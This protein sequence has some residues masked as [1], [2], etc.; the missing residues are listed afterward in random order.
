VLRSYA[1][2]EQK[3]PVLMIN[4]VLFAI[5]II[6]VTFVTIKYTPYI[7]SLISNPEKFKNMLLSYGSKSILVYI[8]FQILHVIIVIIPGEVIQIAGGYVYGTFW[9]T[10]YSTIGI[11]IGM[12]IVFFA[13]RIFGFK[14]IKLL[15]PQ[16]SFDKFTFLINSEKSEIAMFVLFL[17]PGLPKDALSYIVG[18]TPIKPLRFL[19]IASIAR[20]PGLIGS[21]L[22]GA[23]LEKENYFLVIIISVI[24]CILFIAGV[25]GRD[26][27]INMIHNRIKRK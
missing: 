24:A 13:S 12:C 11:V 22:I 3:K 19:L 25:F 23:T 27:I 2:R 4:I 9:G 6:V 1:L 10:I 26:K 20:L 8:F 15:V 21:S 14:L 18:V 17:I 7:M 16:K 5:F